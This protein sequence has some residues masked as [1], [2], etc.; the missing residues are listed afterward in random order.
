MAD[1]KAWWADWRRR[2]P[3]Q[4]WWEDLR[5]RRPIAEYVGELSDRD[6]EAQG[7]V[8]GSAVALRLFLF[9][10]PASVVVVSVVRILDFGSVFDGDQL[11]KGYTTQD[12]AGAMEDSSRWTRCGS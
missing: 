4:T 6:R 3:V 11:E 1:V 8:L 2:K 7:S 12:I 9:L 10:V 5:R